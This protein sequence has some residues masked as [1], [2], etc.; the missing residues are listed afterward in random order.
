MEVWY[1]ISSELCSGSEILQGDYNIWKLEGNDNDN[2]SLHA[3][4]NVEDR[5]DNSGR[6]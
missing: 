3:D 1:S 6:I 5:Y 2:E 4:T